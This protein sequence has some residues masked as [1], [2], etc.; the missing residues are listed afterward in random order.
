[1]VS[2]LCSYLYTDT[3]LQ[4]RLLH[5]FNPLD[6]YWSRQLRVFLHLTLLLLSIYFLQW[7]I[8]TKILIYFNSVTNYHHAEYCDMLLHGITEFKLDLQSGNALSGSNS[9]LF[10]AMWPWNLTN[11]LKKQAWH[12]WH[13]F[14]HF[15]P[16]SHAN[17]NSSLHQTKWQQPDTDLI[18][19]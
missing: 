13:H 17:N 2:I 1:M 10:I 7:H 4:S 11:D 15:S 16:T 12:N 3:I 8:K 18:F 19:T 5:S 9:V 6:I 14:S